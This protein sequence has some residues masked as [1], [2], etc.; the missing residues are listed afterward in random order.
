MASVRSPT[1]ATRWEVISPT[2]SMTVNVTRYWA[3]TTVNERCG[4]TNNRSNSA[5]LANAAATAGPRPSRTAQM[6]TTSR[7]S[8]TMLA[9]S[10]QPR[11]GR[12][13]SAV[14]AQSA[15]AIG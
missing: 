13:A 8:M 14:S 6:K 10:S 7:N 1:R 12:A 2:A 3:S 9:R 4:G 5:T 11:S 15:R